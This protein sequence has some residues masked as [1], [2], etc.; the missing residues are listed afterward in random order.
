VKPMH[1]IQIF[2]ADKKGW[3][4]YAFYTFETV[5]VVM[6]LRM[7]W[8]NAHYLELTPKAE[9][10]FLTVFPIA[11]TALGIT[12]FRIRRL[13]PELARIGWITFAVAPFLAFSL[14]AVT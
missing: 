14:P 9:S 2:S 12:S 10:I 5:V 4:R 8:L 3:W 1:S 7:L 13:Y 11:W 6:A